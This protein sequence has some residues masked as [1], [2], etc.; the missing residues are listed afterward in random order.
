MPEDQIEGAAPA[1]DAPPASVTPPAPVKRRVR[2]Q[3]T[4]TAIDPMTEVKTTT[5]VVTETEADAL[6]ASAALARPT[7]GWWG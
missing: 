1:P 3:A 4:V 7:T 6:P 5:A 2:R